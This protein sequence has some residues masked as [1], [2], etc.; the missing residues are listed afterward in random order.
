MR[1][2]FLLANCKIK[3]KYRGGLSWGLQQK[4]KKLYINLNIWSVWGLFCVRKTQNCIKK[5]YT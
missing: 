3:Y 5:Y 2:I 4:L 1:V